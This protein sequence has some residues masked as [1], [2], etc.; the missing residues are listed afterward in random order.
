MQN[1]LLQADKI[2]VWHAPSP[3]PVLFP[4]HSSSSV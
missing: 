2:V 4:L 3:S 1:T